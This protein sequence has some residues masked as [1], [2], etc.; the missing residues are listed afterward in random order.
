M[1][2]RNG[3]A[4]I[5]FGLV[6]TVGEGEHGMNGEVKLTYIYI[7][8]HTHTNTHTHTHIY[9]YIHIMCKIDNW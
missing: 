9:I 2:G 4:D 5:E 8:T 3:D 6:D 7:Y 1:Q